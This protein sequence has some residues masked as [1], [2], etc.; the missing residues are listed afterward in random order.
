MSQL[1]SKIDKYVLIVT[2]KLIK[3]AILKMGI[4]TNDADGIRHIV[5]DGRMDGPGSDAIG[6]KFTA[7]SHVEHGSIIVDLTEV[8]FLASLGI[9]LLVVNAKTLK[10]RDGLMVLFVGNNEQV[11]SALEASGISQLIPTFSD[12]TEATQAVLA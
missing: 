6:L 7:F 9:R 3:K 8:T 1:S 12:L 4:S 10:S 5:I 11:S 2:L